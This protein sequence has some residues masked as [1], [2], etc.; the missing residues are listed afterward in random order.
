MSLPPITLRYFNCHGRVQH[1]RY[2]LLARAIPF[3]DERIELDE[4]WSA[5][6]EVKNDSEKT[7]PFHKLPMLEWGDLSLVESPVIHDWLH[8]KSGDAALLSQEENLRHAM[9]TSSCMSEFMMPV[10]MLLWVEVTH[11]GASLQGQVEATLPRVK[12]HLSLLEELLIEW[13]WWENLSERKI[14]LADCI[15]WQQLWVIDHIFGEASGI[16]NLPKLD[17]FFKLCPEHEVFENL[18]TAYPLQLTGRFEE[19]AVVKRIQKL[20]I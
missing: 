2:Y 3:T 1:L 17:N 7:G 10:G 12:D 6:L 20:L 16:E 4:H 11:P 14:M 13:Q 5:W 9:L 8:Q 15:L 19:K 18:I